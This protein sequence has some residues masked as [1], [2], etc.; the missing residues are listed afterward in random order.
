MMQHYVYKKPSVRTAMWL[1]D[2]VGQVL[3][4]KRTVQPSTPPKHIVLIILH[5]IGDM[6]MSLP[7]ITA[8]H[9]M[10][11]EAKLTIIATNAPASLLRPNPWQA[12][13]KTFNP[14]WQKVVVQFEGKHL[15]PGEAKQQFVTMV[16]QCH[17]DM[18]VVFHPDVTINQLIGQTDVPVSFGFTNAGGGFHLTHP[19]PLPVGGHQVERTYALAQAIAQTYRVPLPTL[20][21]PQLTPSQTLPHE[22]KKKVG[23]H[24]VVIH[25]YASAPTKNWLLPRWNEIAEWI[26]KQGY[27]P[28]V[29]GGKGECQE[30]HPKAIVLCGALDLAQTAALLHQATLFIG[31]DSGPGHIAAAVDC[32]VVSIFSAV[33]DP[34]RW[35]PY[36]D[37]AQTIILHHDVGNR[38]QFPYES[39]ELPSGTEG[40][41]YSDRITPHE[42][43]AAA[44]KLLQPHRP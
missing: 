43:I 22:I 1:Y 12:E 17:A 10:F 3:R 33:N 6:V 14:P 18:A 21:P 13:I 16:N 38:K 9:T 4:R 44:E 34:K 32:P 11:P 19:L 5:Q 27:T 2:T 29:I 36:G 31:I 26:T 37:M 8:V 30:L 20:A 39:R 28:V 15:T 24:Y 23:D 35:H 25:P 42:V 41:P 7:T 40:N